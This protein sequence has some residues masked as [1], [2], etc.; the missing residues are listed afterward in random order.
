METENKALKMRFIG[1][2]VVVGIGFTANTATAT[3][4]GFPLTGANPHVTSNVMQ[5]AAVMKAT[6]SSQAPAATSSGNAVYSVN[7]VTLN[8][9]TVVREFVATSSGTV[10]AV[11]WSG[12]WQPNFVDILGPYSERFLKPSGAD[13]IRAGGL[14]QRSLSSSDLV[15]ESFGHFGRFI[16]HAYLPSAVPVGV[17]LSELQ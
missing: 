12:P 2:A 7:V 15:V 3:L 17:S 13:V 10:F 9:G 16:G 1:L 6:K 8:S 11:A 4:G 14:S 5:V